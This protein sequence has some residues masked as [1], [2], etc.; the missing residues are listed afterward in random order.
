MA[1][2]LHQGIAGLKP[3]HT[4]TFDSKIEW[5]AKSSS[6]FYVEKYTEVR[7]IDN[8]LFSELPNEMKK[9]GQTI[10]EEFGHKPSDTRMLYIF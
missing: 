8:N 3:G 1:A 4:L 5:M 6:Q 9:I 2:L 7:K 10:S